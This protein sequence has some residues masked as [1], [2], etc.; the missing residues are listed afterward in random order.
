LAV[1]PIGWTEQL[2]QAALRVNARQ[3]QGLIQQ[4]PAEQTHLI[5]GLTDLVDRCCFE[6]LVALSKA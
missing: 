5:R 4:I 6:E 2:Q 1:M 3:L